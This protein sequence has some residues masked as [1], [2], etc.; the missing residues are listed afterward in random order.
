MV[1]ASLLE[2]QRQFESKRYKINCSNS[3]SKKFQSFRCAFIM[4]RCDVVF[5][6]LLMGHVVLYVP[7]A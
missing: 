3:T 2:G 5:M 1:N 4:G 6:H 7:G